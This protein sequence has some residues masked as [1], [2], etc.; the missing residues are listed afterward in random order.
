M[1]M[2]HKV[3]LTD[4]FIHVLH[5]PRMLQYNNKVILFIEYNSAMF[6]AKSSA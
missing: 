3:R 1:A 2:I 5:Y 4:L 6:L